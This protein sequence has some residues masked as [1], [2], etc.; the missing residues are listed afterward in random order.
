MKTLKLLIFA[1]ALLLVGVAA[2]PKKIT[3]YTI[4]DS[5]MSVGGKQF[6]PSY[7]IAMGWGDAIQPFFDEKKLEIKNCGRS[8]RSSKSFIDEGLWDQVLSQLQKGDYLLI[9]FGGNDQ[10]N[11][12]K[13]YTD[14]ETSF[15]DNF[16]KFI[17]EARAKGAI[18]L[19]ATSVVRR[20]FD[21]GGNLVDT[22]GRYVTA[23]E[24]VGEEMNVPV[25]DMK[26]S[27]WNLVQEAGVEGSIALFNHVEPGQVGRYPEGNKDNSH[28]SYI[29]AE[30]VAELFV[31][32]L[33]AS[34]HPLAKY[35]KKRK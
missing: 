32:D 14:P 20:R 16:R 13:R 27:T 31:K 17:T 2:K 23:V 30:K 28:W 12:P 34:K 8:G 26:T 1:A 25:I 4:G 18:P 6:D 5:T 29:G 22:Y 7:D 9:Q 19:L 21:S 11:D 33:K 15:K 3:L 10:K 24:E 35:I